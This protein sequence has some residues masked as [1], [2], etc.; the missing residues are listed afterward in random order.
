MKSTNVVVVTIGESIR[1]QL[2]PGTTVTYFE[3]HTLT[4]EWEHYYYNGHE[5]GLEG[6]ADKEEPEQTYRVGDNI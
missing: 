3:P 2:G 5:D 1:Q 6:T 4:L